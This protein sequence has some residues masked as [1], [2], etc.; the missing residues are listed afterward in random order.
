MPGDADS[1][2]TRVLSADFRSL[3]QRYLRAVA[4]HMDDAAANSALTGMDEQG[5]RLY[6]EA[7]KRC[8]TDFSDLSPCLER[9]QPPFESWNPHHRERE[10]VAYEGAWFSVLRTEAQ[11][12]PNQLPGGENVGGLVYQIDFLDAEER[13]SLGTFSRPP[14]HWRQWAEACATLCEMLA[15]RCEVC[16]PH[17]IVEAV[18]SRDR[19]VVTTPKLP[20]LKS[21]AMEAW[22]A[23]QFGMTVTKIATT[24]SEKYRDRKITQPRVSEQIKLAMEHCKA[25]GLAEDA[26]KVLPQVGHRAP[27]RTFDPDAA[28]QGKRTDGKAHYLRERE[29]QK[30]KDGDDEE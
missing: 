20:V 29:R 24:L 17:P 9:W 10:R 8:Y 6:S 12:F 11:R 15:K 18:S 14:S 30:A 21:W 4:S 23:K 22:K 7:G 5:G 16:E 2:G 28:E 19:G 13:Q 25:S 1:I 3:G 27:A 26:A